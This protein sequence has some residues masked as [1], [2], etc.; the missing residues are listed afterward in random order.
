MNDMN[1]KEKIE[2][3]LDV[4]EKTIEMEEEDHEDNVPCAGKKLRV[5][6]SIKKILVPEFDLK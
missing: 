3:A 4:I 2:N 5:S 6:E 1:D